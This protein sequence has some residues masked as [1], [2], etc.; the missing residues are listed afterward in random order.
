MSATRFIK[1]VIVS[2]GT[3]KVV[4]DD[5]FS[6]DFEIYHITFTNFKGTNGSYSDFRFIYF[7]S[8]V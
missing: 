8:I 6:S 4:V 7:R 3:A 2:S 5:I 1:E